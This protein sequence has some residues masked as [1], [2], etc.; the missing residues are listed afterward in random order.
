M[1]R[2]QGSFRLT[3]KRQKGKSLLEK[4]RRLGRFSG[5]SRVYEVTLEVRT[6]CAVGLRF[7]L[8]AV[9]AADELTSSE[10][11]LKHSTSPRGITF[12]FFWAFWKT[13][14]RGT[15]RYCQSPNTALFRR[16]AAC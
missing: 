14:K 5:K 12:C 7:Q 4:L 16:R 3:Q 2:D 9:S 8:A 15:A 13:L 10:S 1:G 6:A 11:T